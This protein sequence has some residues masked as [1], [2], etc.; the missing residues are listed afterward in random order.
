MIGLA[1]GRFVPIKGL[2]LTEVVRDFQ[3]LSALLNAAE[4]YY[5]EHPVPTAFVAV[6]DNH[7]R[8]R[9]NV[10]RL[11]RRLEEARVRPD[12]RPLIWS[13]ERDPS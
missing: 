10:D 3:K 7:P 2:S 9:L 4:A 1:K 11:L 6:L 12:V 13:L 5:P 8:R